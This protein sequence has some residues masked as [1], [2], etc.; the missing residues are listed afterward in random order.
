MR[1]KLDKSESYDIIIMI[2]C[3]ITMLQ[4]YIIL[5]WYTVIILLRYINSYLIKEHFELDIKAA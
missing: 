3:T 5:L 4:Y 2:Y 1:H